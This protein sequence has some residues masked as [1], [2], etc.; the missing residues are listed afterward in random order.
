MA[1][2][3]QASKFRNERVFRIRFVEDFSAALGDL[4]QP[5]AG[6]GLQRALQ[7]RRRHAEFSRQLDSVHRPRFAHEQLRQNELAKHWDHGIEGG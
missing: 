5:G 7:A 6:H 2:S 1:L 3:K 4:E